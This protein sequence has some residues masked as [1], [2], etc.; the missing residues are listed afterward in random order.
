[1]N[2]SNQALQRNF[3]STEYETRIDYSSKFVSH[4]LKQLYISEDSEKNNYDLQRRIES[5]ILDEFDL[6]FSNNV[7]T[8]F[9]V[10]LFVY[11]LLNLYKFIR[12]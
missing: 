10:I 7:Y 8:L 3:Y 12:E 5:I 9:I 4:L 6:F 1:M 2:K 11:V